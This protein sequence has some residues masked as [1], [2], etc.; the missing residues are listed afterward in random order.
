MSYGL[1]TILRRDEAVRTF[2]AVADFIAVSAGVQAALQDEYKIDPE[3]VSLVH[4]F[5]AASAITAAD[6]VRRRQQL[7]QRL[8]WPQDTAVVGGCGALGWRKGTDLFLQVAKTIAES[9]GSRQVRFLWVGGD[10]NDQGSREFDHDV[11]ALGLHGLCTRVATTDDVVS[12]YAAMDVFAL[13]SREDPFPLVMLEA[14]AQG[15]PT[16]CF[17]RSGG[18]PEFVGLGAGLVAPYLD[19]T[20][21]ADHVLR[22][23]DDSGH[24]RALGDRAASL[25]KERY[26][27]D[28]QAPKLLDLLERVL[29]RS[30]GSA[31]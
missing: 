4:A 11:R 21:F 13:T 15:V 9:R 10:G 27:V 5:V 16:V 28:T 14:G 17:D 3:K 23:I 29:A 6:S 7:F 8:D 31:T 19:T 25:V 1:R 12:Y 26:S 18:G 2:R 24:R 30:E 20:V 22:L